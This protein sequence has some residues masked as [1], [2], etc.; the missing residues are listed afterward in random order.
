MFHFFGKKCSHEFEVVSVDNLPISVAEQLY[1][2][3]PNVRVTYKCKNCPTK[4]V[5]EHHMPMAHERNY[6]VED[7]K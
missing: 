7:F 5:E 2:D 6:T 3:K 4:K 1:T